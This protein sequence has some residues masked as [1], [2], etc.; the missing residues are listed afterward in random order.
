[1]SAGSFSMKEARRDHR[2]Y[3]LANEMLHA[4]LENFFIHTCSQLEE[5][6]YGAKH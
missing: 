4:V 3:S 6:A 1:M 5:A 2:D